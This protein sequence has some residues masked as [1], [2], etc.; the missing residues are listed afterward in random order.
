[1]KDFKTNDGYS[2]RGFDPV[3]VLTAV[4]LALLVLEASWSQISEFY[5]F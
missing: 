2:H 4:V 1:M 5:G 3:I